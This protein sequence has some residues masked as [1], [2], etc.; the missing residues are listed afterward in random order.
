MVAERGRL[1]IR[2]AQAR[3]ATASLSKLLLYGSCL[4]LPRAEIVGYQCDIMHCSVLEVLWHLLVP[5]V[6]VGP[7]SVSASPS[8]GTLGSL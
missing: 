2:V 8:H 7:P 1:D 5:G 4:F 6:A 3:K